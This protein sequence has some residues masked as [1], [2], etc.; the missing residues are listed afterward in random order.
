M[1][2]QKKNLP[3]QKKQ[4]RKSDKLITLKDMPHWLP[5]LIFVLT[6]VIFFWDVL[7]QNAF[8]WEDFIEYVFPVQTFAAVQSA[9]G[10]IPFWNPFSF[11]GMPFMADLQVGFFYP[12]NRILTLFVS[13]DSLSPWAIEFI[14]I[15]HFFIAQIGMY[16]LVRYFK[17]SSYGALISAI[18][19]SF[20]M[21][22]VCHVIHPMIVYHLA[23]LPMI[24]MYFIRGIETKR[25]SQSII[26]GIILGLVMLS[27]HPQILLYI[28]F[29]LGII[30][31]WL[32][33]AQIKSKEVGGRQFV[34]II[35]A[36]VL[37]VLIGV[38]IFLIQYLPSSELAEQSQRS[39]ITYEK[40]TEGSLQ[41]KNIYSAVVP[42]IFGK[43]TGDT[44][45]PATYYNKVNGS[46]QTHFYWETAFYFGLVALILGLLGMLRTYK[47]RTGALLIFIALFGFLFALG[48]DGVIFNIM[49]SFPYFGTFRNPGRMMFYVILAFSILAGFGFDAL[50]K[51]AKDDALK[52]QLPLALAIPL[53]ITLFTATGTLPELLGAPETVISDITASGGLALFF[54][55]IVGAVAYMLYQKKLNPRIGGLVLLLLAFIDL[56]LAGGDFNKGTKN[57]ADVYAL[58]PQLKEMFVP[59]SPD[60]LFRVNTRV[61]KPVSFTAMQRNQG[62]ISRIH[63]VEGYN[64]LVLKKAAIYAP[65]ENI[66]FDLSN[67]KY[68]VKVD[69]QRGSWNYVERNTYYPRA[70]MVYSAVVKPETETIDFMKTAD[71]DFDNVV[72]LNAKPHIALSSKSADSVE[73]NVKI[74]S[75]KSNE[76]T[77]EVNTAEPGI[78]CLSEIWYP[79]WKAY[80]D[81]NPA[82]IYQA[83]N[84]FRAVEIPAGKHK[85]EMKYESAAYATGGLIALLTLILSIAGYFIASKFEKKDTKEQSNKNKK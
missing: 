36:G 2:A 10:I 78:L 72:V 80:I 57:P 67:V 48:R 71:I 74:T 7:F 47:T 56:L 32:L 1:S 68:Q 53:L 73:H 23:W 22:L 37:P 12:L 39:E 55:L 17:V 28:V 13:G 8:F 21:L 81:G 75:Y 82:E 52:W 14:I 58:Q 26:A 63:Q 3:K 50:W 31:I 16:Y 6:T 9:N 35:L 43:V 5:Y 33:V 65:D 29:L 20:S 34:N 51:Q 76:F 49:Y 83:Y 70:R 25:I 11:M 85:V 59:K 41:F 45:M 40:A 15:L 54:V 4:V 18:S 61:Y 19:Y 30:F 24:L 84:S 27:G 77:V 64:P 62:L 42:D 38:G 66:S 79:D 44:Q 46:V 69:M 60:D